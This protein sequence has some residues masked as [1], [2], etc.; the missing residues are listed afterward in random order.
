MFFFS[1]KGDLMWCMGTL[2][3]PLHLKLICTAS[4]VHIV[5]LVG[6]LITCCTRRKPTI[7]RLVFIAIN[8]SDNHKNVIILIAHFYVTKYMYNKMAIV[9]N[10]FPN[11]TV[12]TCDRFPSDICFGTGW[13]WSVVKSRVS[14]ETCIMEFVNPLW[15]L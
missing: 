5:S 7:C 12:M 9:V 3:T 11:I 14:I 2:Y 13:S 4:A 10:L 8:K 6:Y 15:L 1:L